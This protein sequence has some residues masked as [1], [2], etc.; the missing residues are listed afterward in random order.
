MGW[1]NL[2]AH[3]A[4]QHLVS[5]T[6]LC[7]DEG[8]SVGRI[9]SGKLKDKLNNALYRSTKT[10]INLGHD[11]GAMRREGYRFR[12]TADSLHT[13]WILVE[14]MHSMDAKYHGLEGRSRSSMTHRVPVDLDMALARRSTDKR[15]A[16]TRHD[17]S[18][19]QRIMHVSCKG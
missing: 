10:S 8:R 12:Y 17:S 7:T 14:F 9:F 6:V 15:S 16:V 4:P 11:S 19:L 1:T 13:G 18:A 2:H 3:A 5:C